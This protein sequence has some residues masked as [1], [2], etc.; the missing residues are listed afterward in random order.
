[1]T[2]DNEKAVI[3]VG[4][5]LPFPGTLGGFPGFGGVPGAAGAAT[6]AIPGASFGFGTSVQRQDVAL[7]LEIT[8]HVNESDYV[9]LE[10]DNELSDVANENF[11]GLGPATSKRH[12]KSTVTI[13]DQQSIVLG[14][15]IKDRISEKVS[16]VP[17]LGDIPILGYLFKKTERTI[18]KQNLL[19]ILTPYIIKDPNDLRRV[20]ERKIR[21]RKE[22]LERYSAFKDDRDYEAEVDYHRKRGLLEEINRTAIEAERDASELRAAEEAMTAR[23]I[24][25]A[26]E[27]VVPPPDP[28]PRRRL[29]PPTPPPPP[30]GVTT[31]PPP[32]PPTP[33]APAPTK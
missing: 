6:G 26:I 28:P 18:L 33:P 11:N 1:L 29:P 16:K 2:T 17:L 5:N 32:P 7:K 22:F 21:E 24:A 31:P 9:R 27:V 12:V 4:Q 8:P 23:D 10:I 15:L 19:I 20:F 14:G 13:R 3:Q 30:P 25:G